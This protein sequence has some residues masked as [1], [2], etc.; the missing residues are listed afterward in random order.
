MHTRTVFVISDGTGIT[1]ETFGTA[2]MAQF[3]SKPRLMRIP[4]VD[5]MDK[6]TRPCARSTM[7]PRWKAKAHRLHHP[8]QSGDAGPDRGQLQGHAVRHVRHLCA[9]LELELG[10][11][12]LHRVGRFADIS[13]SK[14]YLERI[15]AINFTLAHDDG[16]T[17]RPDGRRRDP[18]GREPQRQDAHQPVP[19]HAVRPQGGQLPADPRRLRAQAAAARAGALP[20]E[21]VRP[22]H[23]PE[24]LSSIRNE[25]RPDSKYA[26]LANCRY[27]V[28]E[29]EAMMR[30]SGIQWLSSTTKSIEEIATTILQE[31]LPQHLGH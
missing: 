19:G 24:R 8:G 15:E 25:R 21:A 26:S 20:Q 16:Q 31:V 29:A 23:Q 1:A 11:K 10:Q 6:A 30:R 27:E 4:F 7:W 18:G 17:H 13:E 5:T 28:A 22:D 14:E 2:I 3:E 9:P 12:S